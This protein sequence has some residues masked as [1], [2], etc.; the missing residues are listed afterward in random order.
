[1]ALQLISA[2]KNIQEV[3]ELF[4]EYTNMLIAGDSTFQ[5]YLDIQNYDEEL[6]HL[7]YK[8]GLPSGRLY[9]AY[10]DGKL[11]GCIG[12]RRIDE[13]NCEMKRLYVRPEFRGKHIGRRLVERVIEDAEEIGYSCMLLDTLPFLE[14]AI[15]L[16]REYGFY[17]IERYNDSPMDHAVYM[18]LELRFEKNKDFLTA[19]EADRIRHTH[20][21]VVGAG[22]LGQMLAHTLVRSG[23][24]RLT[25]ADGDCFTAG[26]ENRQLYALPEN[27]GLKKAEVLRTEL[28]KI[29]QEA[30]IKAADLFVDETNG[31]QLAASADILVDCVDD[32]R[33][34][35]YLEMLAGSLGICLV[36]GAVEGWYGQVS[37]VYPGDGTMAFLYPEDRVQTVS[38]LMATVNVVAS[39]QAAEVIKL[40]A[41]S[42]EMIR[43]RILYVDMRNGDFS[44]VCLPEKVE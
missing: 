37:T 12:L 30:D 22:A 1:M 26:N 10:W 7:E 2:Y 6:K 20:V 23:F 43:R 17:E 38:A 11:A 25:V 27:R 35:K 36:H 31:R 5:N 9:L 34:K 32:I 39:L 33:T 41:G 8:Y 4:S 15:R 28:K 42:G 24:M 29:N 40:A 18:K 3:G 21:M 13:T 16:Y 44:S 19:K 14:S